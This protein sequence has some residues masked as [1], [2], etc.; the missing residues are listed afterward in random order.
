VITQ[1]AT[2]E[3]VLQGDEHARALSPGALLGEH[4]ELSAKLMLDGRQRDQADREAAS[5][6]GYAEPDALYLTVVRQWMGYMQALPRTTPIGRR[7][8]DFAEVFLRSPW[9]LKALRV[10]WGELDLFG[11]HPTHPNIR[12]DAQ[13]LVPSIALSSFQLKIA[14]LTADTAVFR[15]E[16]GSSLRRGRQ[17]SN[18]D[19]VPLWECTAAFPATS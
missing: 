12:L 10:G 17:L 16:S 8:A 7:L 18:D 11:V 14:M 15:T 19:A 6:L 3:K 1:V 2:T 9:S 13:G 5:M 4:A